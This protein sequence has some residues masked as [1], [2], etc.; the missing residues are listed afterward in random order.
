M[1]DVVNDVEQYPKFLPWCVSSEVI[2]SNAELMVAR[3]VLAKGGIRQS[4]STRN[5]LQAPTRID[6]ALM[7]GPFSTLEGQWNFTQLGEDGCKIDM[8]LRFDFD[9]RVMNAALGKVFNSAADRLVDAFCEQA[10]Q[11][12]ER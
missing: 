1:F 3:L 5:T 10:A 9:S 12:Y 11:L 8:R 6:I 2:E 7:A 4:F